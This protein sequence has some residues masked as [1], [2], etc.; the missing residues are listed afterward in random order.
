MLASRHVTSDRS[1][2][3][4]MGSLGSVARKFDRYREPDACYG[5]GGQAV[6]KARMTPCPP[7]RDQWQNA[8][9]HFRKSALSA[10]SGRP[11]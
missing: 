5:S 1:Q 3:V 10:M 11:A 7:H 9:E 6:V 2:A 8:H 4:P